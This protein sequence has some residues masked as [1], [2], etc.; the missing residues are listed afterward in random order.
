MFVDAHNAHGRP[1]NECGDPQREKDGEGTQPRNII[2][3]VLF[4]SFFQ[5][6]MLMLF[7]IFIVFLVTYGPSMIVKIV[8]GMGL[9]GAMI[10]L[11]II[12][13]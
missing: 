1:K 7:T 6:F 13:V 10:K 11:D 9:G 3:D 8:S 4:F 5:L 2:I 12:T